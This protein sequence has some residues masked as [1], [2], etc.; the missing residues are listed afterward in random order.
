MQQDTDLVKYIR[1]RREAYY[2]SCMQNLRVFDLMI[3]ALEKGEEIISEDSIISDYTID[4]YL[5]SKSSRKKETLEHN[6]LDLFTTTNSVLPRF[7]IVR[8]LQNNYKRRDDEKFGMQIS[9]VLSKMNK[10][11]K[12]RKRGLAKKEYLWGLPQF[13]EKTGEIKDEYKYLPQ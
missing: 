11:G 5:I 8:V 2:K 13:F 6:I 12:I 3:D 7:E 9:S 4:Q 10:A 1:K